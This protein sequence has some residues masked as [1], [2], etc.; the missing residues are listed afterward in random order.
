MRMITVPHGC[1]APHC[2]QLRI[3]W[4]DWSTQCWACLDAVVCARLIY[5]HCTCTYME[6]RWIFS[7][8]RHQR[9]SYLLL[10]LLASFPGLAPG[11][12]LCT[13]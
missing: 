6:V 12:R 5:W 2:M 7:C 4:I 8:V 3:H 13:T 11:M 9:L 1:T 10:Y